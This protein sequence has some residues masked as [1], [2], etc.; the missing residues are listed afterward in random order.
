MILGQHAQ[1]YLIILG[2]TISQG[3]IKMVIAQVVR[4]SKKNDREPVIEFKKQASTI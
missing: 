3:S 4:Q 2:T 1:H